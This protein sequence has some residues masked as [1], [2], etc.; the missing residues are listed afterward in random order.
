MKNT[1]VFLTREV[2]ISVIF[3]IDSYK[4][5]MRKSPRETTNKNKQ[6]KIPTN[7]YWIRQR[8]KG[9]DINKHYYLCMEGYLKSRL[10][11]L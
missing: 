8:F 1:V 2:F 9:T 7:F 10:Q 3:S 5:E 6:F 4:Q 11:F